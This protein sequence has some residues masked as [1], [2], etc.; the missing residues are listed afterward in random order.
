MPLTS[1]KLSISSRS[2]DHIFC[3]IGSC[4]ET[5]HTSLKVQGSLKVVKLKERSPRILDEAENINTNQ[6]SRQGSRRGGQCCQGLLMM[7]FIK[8]SHVDLHCA[9]AP[10]MNNETIWPRPRWCALKKRLWW[11]INC[12]M[13]RHSGSP[14]DV[15]VHIKCGLILMTR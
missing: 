13:D 11:Y 4:W 10:K 3:T 7:F 1:T 2:R 8:E 15:I 12:W 9:R 14:P 5:S 6:H